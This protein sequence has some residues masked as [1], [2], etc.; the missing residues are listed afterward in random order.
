MKNLDLYKDATWNG[1]SFW[2]GTSDIFLDS[3]RKTGF[4]TI[5]AGSDLKLLDLLSFLYQETSRQ[6]I[7][8]PT[9]SLN[10]ESIEATIAQSDMDFEGV[11]L[12]FRH[13]QTYISASALR[14]ATYACL[15]HV[16]S[17]LLEK[18]LILLSVLIDSKADPEI[19]GELDKLN[20]RQY[21]SIKAKPIMIEIRDI[22]DNDLLLESG[23]SA[24]S[25]LWEMRNTFPKLTIEE[26]FEKLQ[27]CNSC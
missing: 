24:E 1:Y 8:H 11:L 19:P 21:L 23:E 9:L 14:A 26:Q 7:D 16:G 6:N 2:H 3:I 25:T 18:C 15:N 27:F 20:I 4:G 22:I 12:N 5:N 17:E 10:C 13:K